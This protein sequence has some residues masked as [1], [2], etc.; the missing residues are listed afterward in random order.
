MNPVTLFSCRC[1]GDYPLPRVARVLFS[2]CLFYLLH[3]Y[4][5]GSRRGARGGRP[6]YFKTKNEARRAEKI[7]LRPLPPLSEVLD[8]PMLLYYL[9]TWYTLGSVGKRLSNLKQRLCLEEYRSD[10]NLIPDLKTHLIRRFCSDGLIFHPA[11]ENLKE[12][13]I[14][15]SPIDSGF[16]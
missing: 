3:Y 7:F 6:P 12:M 9:R 10:H 5:G 2:L 16:N 11:V 1:E 13:R 15:T 8:P 14:R 4:S